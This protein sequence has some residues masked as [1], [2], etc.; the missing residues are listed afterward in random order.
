MKRNQIRNA[1]ALAVSLSVLSIGAQAATTATFDSG[2][3]S[4]LNARNIGSAMMSGRIAAVA[5]APQ[6]DGK[7]TVYVGAASGGVWKSTD[8]GT[9]FKPV[10]D[11]QPVQSIGAIAIDPNHHDTVWVGTGESWMRNSVSVGNGIYKTTDGGETWQYL[12][13]PESEHVAKIIIDPR[14]GNTVYA[15]VPGKLW[16]DSSDRGLYKTTD[17]GHS[18]T[19]ILKGKNLSTGCSGLSLDATDPNVLFAAMWDFRRKGWTFRSGG[20]SPDAPSASGLF[21]SSDG[22]RSWTEITPDANKGFPK[23]PY[24]RIAVTIAPSNPQ[25]VY[26]MVESPNSSLYRSDD[27]GKTWSERDKSQNMVW[28]PF[29]FANL[30]VDPTNPDRVFKPDLTLIQS[31]DGGMSFSEVGGGAHGDFHDLWIDPQDP[32]YVIAG[33]DGGLWFSHDGGNKWWKANNLPVSQFYHVSVDD[34]DPYHVYGG[35]Q[36]NSD[37][38]GDSEYPG[39]ITNSRW[40]NMFGGDGFWM[41]ADPTDKN[42]LY[43]ES[44]GGFIGRINRHTHQIQLIQPQAGYKEKLRYNWNTPIA[45]SPNDKNVLYIGAQFLFKSSDRGKTWARISPDLTTNNPEQQKQEESGGVT[46][47]NSYAEMHDTIYSISESPKEAGLIWVGTDDGNLQL[48]RDGGKNWSN[49]VGNIRG[50]PKG[51]WVSWVQA[52]PFDAGTAYVAFDRH[53][54]GDMKPYIYKTT[55]YGRSWAALVTPENS[56]G[57]HGFVHVIKPDVV[58]SNLLFAGTE[59][60]LWI[61]PDDGAHWA[62]FKGSDFPDVPVRDLVVHPRTNDLVVA[63]HGRGIWIV[64]D[65]TPL[66]ALTSSV[67]NSD[68]TF[69]PARPVVQRIQAFG[70]WAEGD[71]SF[72]GPNPPDG[73]VITYYQKSRHLFGKLKLEIYDASGKLVDTLPGNVRR[74][75][76][77]VTWDMRV[78]PPRVP[79]AAQVAFNS[80]QGPRVV[81]GVYTVKLI[82]GDKTY[83]QKLTIGLDPRDPFTLADR[84]AQFDAAMKVSDLFGRMTD[85]D[86][87]IVAVRDAA[88]ARA[89]EAKDDPALQKQLN[90]LADKA[91]TIRKQIV[92]TKEGGAITGE[93]R[94]REYLDDVYGAINGYEGAPTDYQLARVDAIAREMGDTAKDFDGLRNGDLA[95]ANTALKAKGMQEISVPDKAPSDTGGASNGGEMRE[96]DRDAMFERD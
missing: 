3:I 70:G 58:D 28:R 69:L 46:V 83:E 1:L 20:P 76:N 51:E 17:G 37:W 54:F 63:T 59:F 4:G 84:K 64:D 87:Q 47:D 67:L 18:W 10:F 65:I 29:Y 55:D 30:I 16:S 31:T 24:G 26:A 34:D 79:P 8:N 71:A 92:A 62:R 48:T 78:A 53:S 80:A 22:G 19:L 12:G 25:I 27:G 89:A 72:S 50:L 41:F 43:A 13:L 60:G 66:R 5:A 9:T 85:L 77:R 14:D 68:A 82:K 96:R 88:K 23:K 57:I 94:E 52:S 95:K 15:C 75:I 33:D 40:E 49:V 74:G 73:W 93:E 21:K 86:Y 39:G 90:A 7:I 61:S 81:P 6:S 42:Y 35:L 56:K 32:K 45:L 91:D 11:K 2:A 38:V 36:D 44:Q